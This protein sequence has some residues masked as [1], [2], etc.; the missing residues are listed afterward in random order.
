M[1][2]IKKFLKNILYIIFIF[3][4]IFLGIFL[5][6]YGGKFYLANSSGNSVFRTII[7]NILNSQETSVFLGAIFGILFIFIIN[8]ILKPITK[9][10][11]H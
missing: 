10:K 11:K 6:Q 1:V 5:V 3:V 2:F 9:K 7:I 8:L 4:C